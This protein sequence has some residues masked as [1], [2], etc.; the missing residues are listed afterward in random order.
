MATVSVTGNDTLVINDRILVDLADANVGELN[1]PN[2][3]AV[4][5]TGKNGN[6]IYA[7]NLAGKQCTLAIRLIRGSSDD[8]FLNGLLAQQQLNFS[9]F[10]LMTGQFIKQVGDGQGNVQSDTYIL[11]GGVFQKQVEAKTNVDGDTDQS[12]SVYNI[13]F[14]NSPRVIT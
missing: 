5:K 13:L 6:S 4:L 9:G 2:D 14:S 11:S 10:V 1:Y 8:K 3:V 12:V 7:E